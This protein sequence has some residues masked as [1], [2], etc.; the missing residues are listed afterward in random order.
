MVVALKGRCTT[1]PR[2]SASSSRPT[3]PCRVAGKEGMD[4]LWDQTKGMYVPGQERRAQEI[5]QADR[6]QRH[7][8]H[9]QVPRSG[10]TKEEWKMVAETKKIL[11]TK[12]KV[13]ATC[14]AG[15]GLRRPFRGDQH[16]V[17]G[18]PRRGRGARHSLRESPGIMVIDKREDGGYVTPVECVGRLRHLHQPHPPGQHDRQWPE[19][20]VRVRQPAQGR[21]AERGADRRDAGQPGD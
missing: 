14:G 13:T 11:D 18:V 1:A 19:P 8:A 4:E 20:V 10:E 17:R 6:L 12:I 2:S 7:P 21:G 16:R 9:R 15:A 3:S 5:H